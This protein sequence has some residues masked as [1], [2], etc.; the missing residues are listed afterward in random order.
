MQ[1]APVSPLQVLTSV[2]SRFLKT[3]QG[4]KSSGTGGSCVTNESQKYLLPLFVQLLFLS[5]ELIELI[6]FN[7]SIYL[8]VCVPFQ[9]S[10]F[11][12][13]LS[14]SVFAFPS[15]AGALGKRMSPGAAARHSQSA[16]II[17]ICAKNRFFSPNFRFSQSRPYVDLDGSLLHK[18]PGKLGS[19]HT[20]ATAY[21]YPSPTL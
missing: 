16:R 13:S 6:F 14:I 18:S 4:T 11:S 9:S 8:S 3:R 10:F 21:M 19:L 2:L 12:I 5:V 15:T 17:R 1:F 7:I 20:V